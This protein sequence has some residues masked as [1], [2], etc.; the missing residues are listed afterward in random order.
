MIALRSAVPPTM[1]VSDSSKP[2]AVAPVATIATGDNVRKSAQ[3][4]ETTLPL[5]FEH[6]RF[7]DVQKA[8]SLHGR[9]VAAAILGGSKDVENRTVRLPL[10]VIAVHTSMRSGDEQ[11]SSQMRHLM[12][13]LV[14]DSCTPRGAVVGLAWVERVV[15]VSVLRAESGCG[16]Q[17][18]F[19]PGPVGSV[20]SSDCRFSPFAYGPFCNVL[21]AVMQLPQPVPCAGSTGCIP[22]SPRFR[23][24]LVF[25]SVGW[26]WAPTLSRSFFRMELHH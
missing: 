21:S 26:G 23:R 15:R 16:E 7:E 18:H 17:C 24:L 8:I 13:W 5:S 3:Q 14:K 11:M 22:P 25:R 1:H 6:P 19:V 20:H 12:P 10:G 9:E 4:Q 2:P